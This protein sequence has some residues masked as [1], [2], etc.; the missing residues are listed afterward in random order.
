ML[1]YCYSLCDPLYRVSQVRGSL[2]SNPC[3]QLLLMTLPMGLYLQ[4]LF[5]SSIHSILIC[6]SASQISFNIKFS[7]SQ[8]G[9][10]LLFRSILPSFPQANS[11]TFV[12]TIILALLSNQIQMLLKCGENILSKLFGE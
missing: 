7:A 2:I 9:D 8:G 12:N 11:C 10:Y 3:V 5:I 4:P 1:L 6:V